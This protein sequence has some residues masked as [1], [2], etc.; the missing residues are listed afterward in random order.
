MQDTY[1]SL[2]R[3]F[4]GIAK[5]ERKNCKISSGFYPPLQDTRTLPCGR[6]REKRMLLIG[7]CSSLMLYF[8]CIWS[9]LPVSNTKTCLTNPTHIFHL[10]RAYLSIRSWDQITSSHFSDL[11]LVT[12]GHWWSPPPEKCCIIIY[13]ISLNR[14]SKVMLSCSAGLCREIWESV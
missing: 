13:L 9:L 2:S 6:A 1:F 3:T 10:L 5:K 12:A 14:N 11:L 8:A 4:P 7:C